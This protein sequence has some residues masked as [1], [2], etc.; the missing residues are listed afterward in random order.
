[1]KKERDID[2]KLD[3]EE[4]EVEIREGESWWVGCTNKSKQ[5]GP[6]M[7]PPKAMWRNKQALEISKK[8][9]LEATISKNVQVDARD[10]RLIL[11]GISIVAH[12]LD[13]WRF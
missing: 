2:Y 13:R 1:M 12:I 10:L 8:W 9:L 7:L 3:K 4:E 11:F 6:F 5:R